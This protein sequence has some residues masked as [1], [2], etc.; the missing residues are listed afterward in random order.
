VLNQ[1][2]YLGDFQALEAHGRRVIRVHLAGQDPIGVLEDLR[3]EIVEA[4]AN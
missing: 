3:Q 2:Q 1:A 4:I